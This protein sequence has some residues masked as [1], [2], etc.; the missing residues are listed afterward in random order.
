[1]KTFVTSKLW[2]VCNNEV[3]T[4]SL[5]LAW[6][7]K[8]MDFGSEWPSNQG[9]CKVY[10]TAQ[11]P[12]PLISQICSKC[13]HTVLFS[14]LSFLLLVPAIADTQ[15]AMRWAVTNVT[16]TW[17]IKLTQA[18]CGMFL[19]GSWFSPAPAKIY[20]PE[21]VLWC[22]LGWITYFSLKRTFQHLELSLY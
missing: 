12:K 13:I 10:M 8:I 7:Y 22:T 9:S 4:C 1:M 6:H 19:T 14:A 18:K 20:G 11:T 2:W 3:V 16:V 5:K 21:W 17:W 15:A